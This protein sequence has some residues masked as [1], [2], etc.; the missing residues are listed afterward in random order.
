MIEVLKRIANFRK[1][2]LTQVTTAIVVL[3][4]V[5]HSM[6]W[7]DAETYH[8]LAALFGT[9]VVLGVARKPFQS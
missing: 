7:I 6:G 9:G 1:G 3:A 2:Q 8:A 5:A 4:G